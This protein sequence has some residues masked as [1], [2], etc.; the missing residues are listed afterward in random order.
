MITEDLIA[1]VFEYWDWDLSVYLEKYTKKHKTEGLDINTVKSF[2]KQLLKGIAFCHKKK[3][4]HRDL[5]PQNILISDDKILKIADFGLARTFGIP[6]KSYTQKV[7]TLYYRAPELLLEWNKYTTAIDIWSVGWIFAELV[8]GKILFKK[9]VEE[10]QFDFIC[11]IRG[12]PSIEEWPGIVDLPRYVEG[13][14][15]YEKQD[16]NDLLPELGAD[17]VDLLDKL[18]EYNPT[19][20]ITAKDALNHPFLQEFLEEEE[21]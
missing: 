16:L 14:P 15:K 8:N 10:E 17:G 20:R 9:E 3:I 2:L 1:L 7:V 6:F 11:Q 21:Q 19:K 18:L 13:F 12:T 4:L 5:K